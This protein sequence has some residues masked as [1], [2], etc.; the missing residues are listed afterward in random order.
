MYNAFPV[1]H[2]VFEDAEFKNLP[3]VAKFLYI[4]LSKLSNRYA[5]KNGWFWVSNK[6]LAIDTKMN[7]KSIIKGKKRLKEMGFLKYKTT[8]FHNN[9]LKATIYKINHYIDITKY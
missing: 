6:T 2:Q 1:S 7:I 3:L 9:S 5:D 8:T 4:Q